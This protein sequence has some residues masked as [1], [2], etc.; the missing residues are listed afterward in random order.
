MLQSIYNFAIF[1]GRRLPESGGVRASSRAESNLIT[2]QSELDIFP[3]P[4]SRA[5][6]QNDAQMTHLACDWQLELNCTNKALCSWVNWVLQKTSGGRNLYSPTSP[7]S[8]YFGPSTAPL[9]QISFSP[10]PT[11][12]IKIKGGR[13]AAI[14]LVRKILSSRSP[15]LRLLCRLEWALF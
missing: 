3:I 11:A 4:P 8:P 14:I 13:P 1:E 7:Q 5:K 9:V 6:C 15:K 2:S 10:K 12:A